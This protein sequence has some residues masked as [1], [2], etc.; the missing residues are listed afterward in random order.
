MKTKYSGGL[1]FVISEPENRTKWGKHYKIRGP[2]VVKIFILIKP[3][4]GRIVDCDSIQVV[5]S[6][7]KW[8]IGKDGKEQSI[9]KAYRDLI[10]SAKKF[11]YIE[12]QFFVSSATNNER[13]ISKKKL[14][15]ELKFP[16]NF[17]DFEK[18]RKDK[19]SYF[20][21]S[22]FFKEKIMKFITVIKFKIKSPNILLKESYKPM[23]KT[24]Y[25]KST[26]WYRK[27]PVFTVVWRIETHPNRW[28]LMILIEFLNIYKGAFLSPANAQSNT[29]ST[30]DTS[31]IEWVQ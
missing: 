27:R 4:W 19:S 8:S 1:Y 22:Q 11:I 5:R 10:T 31:K 7:G 15:A 16:K 24:N 18:S 17:R 14:I 28:I 20:R 21:K 9:Y 6:V 2:T 12:N 23:W 3:F 13:K 30:L 29:R 25:S 26:L